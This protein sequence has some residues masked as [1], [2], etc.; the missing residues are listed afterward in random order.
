MTTT[1]P[2][3]HLD[4]LPW[5]PYKHVFNLVILEP[6]QP[7]RQA[8]ASPRYVCVQLH[9]GHAASIS[10]SAARC[11][12]SDSQRVCATLRVGSSAQPVVVVVLMKL[13]ALQMSFYTR[14]RLHHLMVFH[15]GRVLHSNFKLTQPHTVHKPELCPSGE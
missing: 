8:S 12:V 2:L 1:R 13:A 15:N 3:L 5:A 10:T 9:L 6:R 14:L 7:G 4:R 11:R